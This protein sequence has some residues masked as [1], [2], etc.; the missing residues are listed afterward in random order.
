M[1]DFNKG[2]LLDTYKMNWTEAQKRRTV[3]VQRK[4]RGEVLRR[5]MVEAQRK[6][7]VGVVIPKKTMEGEEVPRKTREVAR[8]LWMEEAVVLP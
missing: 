2:K 1:R 4:T 6:K 5:R 7:R 3:E 8:L